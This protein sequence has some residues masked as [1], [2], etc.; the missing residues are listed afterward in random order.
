[1]SDLKSV[2]KNS[3]SALYASAQRCD[4]TFYSSGRKVKD[5]LYAKIL[6]INDGKKSIILIT[7][8]T[9]AIGGRE[10]TKGT[11][12]DTSKNFLPKLRSSIEKISSISGENI[13]VNASHTH[14]PGRLLIDED[15]IID[16]I[17]RTVVRAS[18]NM[19][20]AKAGYGTGAEKR[21]SMNRTVTLRDGRD[22]TIRH[23]HP[24]PPED[25]I[26]TRGPVDTGV[27]VIR[28][29]HID[30]TPLAVVYNFACHLL[31]ANPQNDLS[32]NIPGTASA[33][34]EKELGNDA[35]ALFLQGAAG[36][37][38]DLGYKNFLSVRNTE[39]YGRYL[40]ESTLR[41]FKK[42][43]PITA[44]IDSESDYIALPRR[45][46]I[47]K[48]IH[49]L[50]KERIELSKKTK[51]C[52][53]DLKDYMDCNYFYCKKT[54]HTSGK[55]TQNSMI[56]TV[57]D[58]MRA[59]EQNVR[60][61]NRIIVINENL[62]TLRFHKSLIDASGSKPFLSQCLALRI[63]NCVIITTATEL[64]TAPAL[65]LKNKSPYAHTIIAAYSNG[66]LHYG[67]L[68]ESYQKGGYE[69]TECQLAP[70]WYGMYEKKIL[71]MLEMIKKRD[72]LN[73]K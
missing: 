10:I 27:Y 66:Y 70:S 65:R 58:K 55:D 56:H 13:L 35:V 57:R 42:I 2:C 60:L 53:F 46:D 12:P 67:A 28:I 69:V 48:I 72:L 32:A 33:I 14:P 6:I 30:G 31:W 51:S 11:L 54:K 5:P 9:T 61:L 36:D 47:G 49:A 34:I 16:R 45:R 4:L 71:Q 39:K 17:T 38:C 18:K 19:R 59:F 37:I 44:S 40:A 7:I 64:L 52:S 3:G 43:R 20:P 68:P 41:I 15:K 26:L 21:I 50:E 22:W 1:M 29:D 25:E 23:A 8:D 24:S 62:A 63:G 73:Y